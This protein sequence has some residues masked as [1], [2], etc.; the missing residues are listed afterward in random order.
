MAEVEKGSGTGGPGVA[1]A[2]MCKRGGKAEKPGG[3]KQVKKEKKGIE[4]QKRRKGEAE[5]PQASTCRGE[6]STKHEG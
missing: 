5:R 1:A 3:H 6:E 4:R 2:G